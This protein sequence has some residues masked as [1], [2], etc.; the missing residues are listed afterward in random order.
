VLVN[1]NRLGRFPEFRDQGVG[2]SNPL[3]PTNLFNG[4]SLILRASSETRGSGGQP[5]AFRGFGAAGLQLLNSEADFPSR[6][7]SHFLRP[8][9]PAR[10]SRQR[11]Y[12]WAERGEYVLG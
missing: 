10:P 5:L 2:G 1:K 8:L 7:D 12:E 11:W 9:L 3:S 4:L 6:V